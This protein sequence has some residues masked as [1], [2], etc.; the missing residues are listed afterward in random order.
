MQRIVTARREF[1][2]HHDQVLHAADLARKN[3]AIARQADFFRLLRILHRRHDQG[4]AHDVGRLSWHRQARIVIHHAAEQIRVQTSPIDADAHRLAVA[5][6]R[7][8]HC[9]EL[10]IALRPATNVTGIDAVLVED[11]RA[12]RILR[13]QFVA[14]EMKITDERYAAT[15][16]FEQVADFGHGRGRFRAIDRDAHELRT[17]LREIS[18]LTGG[19]LHVRGISIGH[20][21]HND[22]RASTHRNA[23]NADLAGFMTGN[24]MAGHG[25][26]GLIPASAARRP[27]E[28]AVPDQCFCHP[29]TDARR[30]HG[31]RRRRGEGRRLRCDDCLRH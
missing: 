22:R 3:D 10:V 7:F 20:R 2:V 18:H 31:Q 29:E 26:R 17:G 27:R 5:A 23:G 19:G 25:K 11:L 4:L 6:C 15:V 28:C 1:A 9:R 8:D 12:I 13:Q 24:G 16:A 21:L 30:R 14:I